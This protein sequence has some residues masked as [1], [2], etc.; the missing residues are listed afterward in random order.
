MRAKRLSLPPTS[1]LA[2]AAEPE[3]TGDEPVV[4]A[5]EQTADPADEQVAVG[6]GTAEAEQPYDDARVVLR[7]AGEGD[8]RS[9]LPSRAS[10]K[11]TVPPEEA[12]RAVTPPSFDTVRITPDGRAVIAGRAPPESEVA[13]KS[14]TVDLGSETANRQGEWTLVPYIPIPPG[15]HQ[16]SADCDPAGRHASRVRSRAHRLGPRTRCGR[17]SRSAFAVRWCRAKV[18]AAEIVQKPDRPRTKRSIW[19]PRTKRSIQLATGEDD[20]SSGHGR[21]DRSG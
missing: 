1:R 8:G 11:K 20:R 19:P 21:R 10:R 14:E 2:A 17:R 12:E 18:W 16:F 3:V 5:D 9:R 4:A 13:V 6:E 15:D 7:C